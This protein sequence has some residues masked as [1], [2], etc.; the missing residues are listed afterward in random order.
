MG[1]GGVVWTG[2]LYSKTY[3]HVHIQRKRRNTKKKQ[4]IHVVL[5]KF[6]CLASLFVSSAFVPYSPPVLYVSAHHQS[7]CLISWLPC[8]TEA[9]ANSQTV[10]KGTYNELS[11]FLPSSNAKKMSKWTL[12]KYIGERDRKREEG[13]LKLWNRNNPTPPSLCSVSPLLHLRTHIPLKSFLFILLPM[14]TH[15]FRGLLLTTMMPLFGWVCSLWCGPMT[16]T[17]QKSGSVKIRVRG[18]GVWPPQNR[19][20]KCA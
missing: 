8:A 10:C 3:I 9:K 1:R 7:A 16:L 14:Y 17:F 15:T 11:V 18:V 13:H 19:V 6:C 5:I 4:H 12:E 2:R 20:K